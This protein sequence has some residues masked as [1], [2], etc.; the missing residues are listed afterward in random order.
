MIIHCAWCKTITGSKPPF[1]ANYDSKIT[2][3][4][5]PICFERVMPKKEEKGM[6]TAKFIKNTLQIEST[7]PRLTSLTVYNGCPSINIHY[8]SNEDL[9]ALINTCLNEEFE[10]GVK[11]HEERQRLPD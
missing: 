1:G 4:I 6:L 8:V 2:D 9:D 10:R 11:K 7:K 3:G 5:C